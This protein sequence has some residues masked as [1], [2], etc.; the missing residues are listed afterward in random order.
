MIP[1]IDGESS[2]EKKKHR[3]EKIALKRWERMIRR[4]VDLEQINLKLQQ[5]VLDGVDILSFQPMYS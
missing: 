3:K 4:G 2:G 5:M 1:L